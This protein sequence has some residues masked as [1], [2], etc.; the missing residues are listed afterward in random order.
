[1]IGGSSY[2]LIKAG[3]GTL[4]LTGTSNSFGGPVYVN[5]GTLSVTTIGTSGSASSLGTFGTI[6]LGTAATA[7]ALLY[8]GTGETTSKVLNLPGNGGRR[9]CTRTRRR[10]RAQ[11]DQQP[12]S[13]G[14]RCSHTHAARCHLR[15][16]RNGGFFGGMGPPRSRSPKL[17]WVPGRSVIPILTPAQQL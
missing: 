9:R 3:A 12:D 11:G 16:G 14:N 13:D 6:A 4:A 7:G 2:G 10:G 17:V 5:A 1:V 8:A 15:H